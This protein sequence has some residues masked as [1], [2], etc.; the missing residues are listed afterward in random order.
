[1]DIVDIHE[2]IDAALE[3]LE[4]EEDVRIVYACESGSRAWGFESGDSDYDVRFFYLHPAKRYLSVSPER[5]VIERPLDNRMDIFGWD[6]R[7]AL[8]LLRKS[9]PPLLEWLQSPIVYRHLPSVVSRIR[10]LVPQYYSPAACHHYLL[11]AT[12]NYREY[13]HGEQIWINVLA[14][15][16][17]QLDNGNPAHDR[18][19]SGAAVHTGRRPAQDRGCRGGAS[20]SRILLTTGMETRC[21][22]PSRSGPCTV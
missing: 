18:G 2:R 10:T 12:K 14:G 13:L 7:K 21:T 20:T 17:K 4:Q 5:G 19:G 6:L 15:P 16:R 1:V 8:Q 22:W 3:K 9:N 11:L